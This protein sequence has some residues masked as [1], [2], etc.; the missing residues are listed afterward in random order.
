MLD[1]YYNDFI[2]PNYRVLPDFYPILDTSATEFERASGFTNNYTTAGGV[3]WE[4][5]NSIWSTSPTSNSR[6]NFLG[7]VYNTTEVKERGNLEILQVSGT[8]PGLGS[9]DTGLIFIVYG[10]IYSPYYIPDLS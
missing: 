3:A 7:E 2:N 8:N 6:V 9:I 10:S 1:R 4:T 5:I